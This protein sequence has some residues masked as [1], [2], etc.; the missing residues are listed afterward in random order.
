MSR[1]LRQRA[2]RSALGPSIIGR[3]RGG[4]D[5]DQRA[6]YEHLGEEDVI[7]FDPEID[8]DQVFDDQFERRAHEIQ[9]TPGAQ[10]AMS[11]VPSRTG[12]WTGNNNLGI[13]RAFA[14]DADNHQTILKMPE[15]GFPEVWTLS[16]GLTYDEHLS[17]LTIGAAFGIVAE[18]Q[19]GSGGC[20]QFAEV[21]WLQGTT[22]SLPMNA[23][24]VVASYDIFLDRDPDE[25]D[26][27][28]ELPN[29]IRLRATLVRGA[30]GRTH[31]TRTYRGL[32]APIP[33][34][35]KSLKV[36][37]AYESLAASRAADFYSS[38]VRVEF[39][40][41]ASDGVAAGT[42]VALMDL[43]QCTE[44][45]DVIERTC[46]RPVEIPI[47]ERARGVRLVTP[48]LGVTP[49]ATILQFQLSL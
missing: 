15:W 45:L 24:N 19:F 2:L 4:L 12:P 21:D 49:L 22:L 26:P 6:F 1:Y 41:L 9:R 40:S 23:L 14:P 44:Y 38:N 31:A 32:T 13:E 33:P 25:P 30:H 10:S 37:P 11:I 47:P 35:A 27:G 16:L 7:R 43:C 29:G 17:A 3:A 20:I 48:S 39:T 46:G 42:T 5:P 18:L 36:F 8:Q 34:F 28:F